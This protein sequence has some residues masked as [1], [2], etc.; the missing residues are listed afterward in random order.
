MK[1]GEF[2]GPPE[3]RADRKNEEGLTAEE[4]REIRRNKTL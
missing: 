3:E 1:N 2:P 4:I